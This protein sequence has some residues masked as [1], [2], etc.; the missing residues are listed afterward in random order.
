MTTKDLDKLKSEG[1]IRGYSETGKAQPKQSKFGNQRC[2]Y[3]G[4]KFDSLRERKR[5]IELE[6]LEKE[7]LVRDLRRQVEYELN[8]GG[9]HSLKYIADFVYVDCDTSDLVVEDSKGA[10]TVVYKKKKKLMLKI[11]GITIKET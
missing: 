1:K 2:E 11:H 6:F 7:G 5:F 4:M 8:E 9:T 3:K 10:K